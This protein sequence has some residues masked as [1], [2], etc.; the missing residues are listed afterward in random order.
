MGYEYSS[1]F[2]GLLSVPG[3][4]GERGCSS[5]NALALRNRTRTSKCTNS[6]FV[7][8]NTR[9]KCQEPWRITYFQNDQEKNRHQLSQLLTYILP[10]GKLSVSLLLP[11]ERA[12]N[13]T[14]CIGAQ[15]ND[16][17]QWPLVALKDI[18]TGLGLQHWSGSVLR[19]CPEKLLHLHL[20][21]FKKLTG[22]G[23]EQSALTWKWYQLWGE[24]L[25]CSRASLQSQFLY[26]FSKKA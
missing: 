20:W 17:K 10:K 25:I 13:Q 12:S 18:P 3:L 11:K 23:P 16:K 22:Q 7:C 6:Y 2:P 24:D 1:H 9:Q 15:G 19:C 8:W 21:G 26:E 14:L 4:S 5:K